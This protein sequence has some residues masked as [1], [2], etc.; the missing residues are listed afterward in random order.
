MSTS[1]HRLSPFNSTP[2]Y[3]IPHST[4]I[5]GRLASTYVTQHITVRVAAMFQTFTKTQ[6]ELHLS[7]LLLCKVTDNAAKVEAMCSSCSRLFVLF[8]SL[9]VKHDLKCSCAD[10]LLERHSLKMNRCVVD[11]EGFT[12][13]L[14]K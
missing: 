10:K 3:R 5:P 2:V 9:L 12:G 11:I 4:L 14:H 8:F 13:V 7:G 6:T 1:H